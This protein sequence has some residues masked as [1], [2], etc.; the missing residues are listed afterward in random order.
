M[1]SI[2]CANISVHVVV[3][4]LAATGDHRAISAAMG[5]NHFTALM[6][7]FGHR[8]CERV[9]A[10]VFPGFG[11]YHDY[12]GSLRGAVTQAVRFEKNAA[13]RPSGLSSIT[14][15]AVQQTGGVSQ[16]PGEPLARGAVLPPG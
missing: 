16:A 4:L 14:G 3:P 15:V 6:V 12:C 7:T 8:K 5:I 11:R 10:L 1:T 2:A 13:M 9:F